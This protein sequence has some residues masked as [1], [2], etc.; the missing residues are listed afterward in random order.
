MA[1]EKPRRDIDPMRSVDKV[2]LGIAAASPGNKRE[3][4]V[5]RV[6]DLVDAAAVGQSSFVELGLKH[7]ACR[8]AFGLTGR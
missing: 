2:A 6:M 8:Q 3:R 4:V 5:I 7:V 1:K